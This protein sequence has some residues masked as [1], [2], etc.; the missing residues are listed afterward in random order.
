[1]EPLIERIYN[2]YLKV[3]RTQNNKPFR[4]RKNFEG[5]ESE[6]NYLPA[7]RLEGFFNRHPQIKLEDF[8]IA[9]YV[10]FSE[11]KD[12]FYELSF[13][14]SQQAIKIYTMYNKKNLMEDPD[15]EG[16]LQKIR[17]GLVFIRDFCLSKKI[18]LYEYPN[19]KSEK[20]H[21]FLI[22]LAN[23]QIS[24]YNLF[25]LKGIDTSIKQYDFE[26]LQFV[27]KDIAPRISYLRTK[28]YA[29]TRAK[30]FSAAGL[31]KIEKTISTSL[32]I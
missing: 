14:N 3:S 23:K 7:L 8:F 16:Q 30:K 31:K 21:D 12:N 6:K 24:I 22:H 25:P 9:P 11:E 17:E 20:T 4:Y 29:S 2:T 19:Y 15:S 13:Y 26:L 10:I 18:H 28:F 5:F 27:L 32:D 1:M